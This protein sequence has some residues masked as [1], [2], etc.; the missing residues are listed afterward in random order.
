MLVSGRH[1]RR[2]LLRS[3]DLLVR[4]PT[5]LLLGSL[6]LELQLALLSGHPL[7]LLPVFLLLSAFCLEFLTVL[8]VDLPLQ[9]VLQ[10]LLLLQLA[11]SSVPTAVDVSPDPP[12]VLLV[13]W[14][15]EYFGDMM[16]RLSGW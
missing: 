6:L 7:H 4:S 1:R 16:W 2:S 10:L 15:S 12:A 3:Q 11:V 5:L 9:C 13:V 8:V 14:S